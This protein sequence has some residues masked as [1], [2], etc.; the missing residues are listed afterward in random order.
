[1]SNMRTTILVLAV[2]LLGFTGAVSAQD[3]CEPDCRTTSDLASPA[4]AQLVALAPAALAIG[5]L[6]VPSRGPG[7]E[8]RN[9]P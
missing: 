7:E 5:A 3:P 8:G 1:M 4:V 2:V 6:V 9:L